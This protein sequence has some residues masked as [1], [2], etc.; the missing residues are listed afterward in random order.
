MGGTCR[1]GARELRASC[2]EMLGSSL[3]FALLV[4]VLSACHT[5]G[6]PVPAGNAPEARPP[7]A[8][9]PAGDLHEVRRGDTLWS[10]S[11]Q[12]GVDVD[13]LRQANRLGARDE[14]RVGQDLVVPGAMR[15]HV[16]RPGETLWRIAKQHGSTVGA[17]A[18]A[19][20]I[21]DATRL[22]VGQ[23]L[24]VP[25]GGQRATASPDR[26]A[27]VWTSSDRRGRADPAGRFVWP[28][29]GRVS[30]GFGMR[31]NHHHDGVDIIAPR[32]TP[33]YAAASGR[34]IH[35]DASLSGYGKMVIIKHSDRYSTV[36]AHNDQLHVK[37][38]QFVEK[39]QRIAVVGKTGRASSPHLH[40]EVR[41]D[42]RPRNPLGHLR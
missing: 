29:R 8:R 10:I 34:V 15:S 22:S 5:Q 12:H 30:S 17:I 23:R 1:A 19:N 7:A 36:Y 39:G 42:G 32:G 3:A 40:F 24:S 13:D 31:R 14:L 6:P 41:Y 28:V 38:G 4:A 16:V 25:A 2:R 35:A 26:S 18:Q 21:S 37:V 9:A 27:R 11:K 20:E 33:V